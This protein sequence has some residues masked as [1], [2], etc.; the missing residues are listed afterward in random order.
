M[1]DI[2]RD[3][4]VNMQKQK[5]KELKRKDIIIAIL[6]VFLFVEPIVFYAGHLWYESQYEYTETTTEEQKVEVS[7]SG[8]NAN[9]EY[10]D[11]DGN[12]YND[13][14]THNESGETE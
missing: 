2:M 6:V 9:A 13:N 7:T 10:N 3:V 14:A 12:Q 1:D 4:F 5:N 8:D 11:V